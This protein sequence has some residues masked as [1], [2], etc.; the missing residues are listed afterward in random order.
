MHAAQ[1]GMKDFIVR[2]PKEYFQLEDDCFSIVDFHDMYRLL[3]RKE[4]NVA[5][6]TL[7]AM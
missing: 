3:R 2:A 6:V 5:Q 7:F 1:L 4:L